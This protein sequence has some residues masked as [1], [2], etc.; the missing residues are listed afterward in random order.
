V[1]S[2]LDSRKGTGMSTESKKVSRPTVVEASPVS[3]VKVTLPPRL[4]EL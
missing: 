3:D 1:I 2:R 4:V